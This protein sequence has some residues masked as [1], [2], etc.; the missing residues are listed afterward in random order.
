MC[1]CSL[2]QAQIF[3]LSAEVCN[4]NL[5][6]FVRKKVSVLFYVCFSNWNLDPSGELINFFHELPKQ[7]ALPV[8]IEYHGIYHVHCLIGF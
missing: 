3:F 2:R 5:E 8:K 1:K 7:L 6:T 4:L